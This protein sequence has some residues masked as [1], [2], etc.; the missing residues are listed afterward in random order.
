MDILIVYA[1]KTGTTEKCAGIIAQKLKNVTV[2]N[3]IQESP[4]IS[5]YDLI[6]VGSN[7]RF[8]RLNRKVMKFISTNK[9]GLLNKK[10]AYYICCG[11][12]DGYKKYLDEGIPKEL[13]EKA[14]IYETFGGEMDIEK[15]NGLDKLIVKMVSKVT[16]GKVETKMLYE[17]IDKF[18]AKIEG[19]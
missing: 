15:Q 18:I 16:E 4:D 1:G 14:I 11:F 17:N 10:V 7:V 3:L 9:T 5:K 12:V 6:I 13:L 8:G 19:D 2:V